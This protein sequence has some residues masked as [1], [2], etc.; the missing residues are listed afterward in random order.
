[1]LFRSGT[2]KTVTATVS[3]TGADAGNYELASTSETDTADI[4]A[5]T[6]TAAL[7][8]DDKVYDGTTTATGACDVSGD[9][10]LIVGDTVTC[11]VT[12]ATFDSAT[13]GTGKTVTATVTLGGADAGGYVLD[14]APITDTAD[15]TPAPLGILFT[16]NG[17][18]PSTSVSLQATVSGACKAGQ[19]VTFILDANTNGNFDDD[20]VLGSPTTNTAGVA[21]FTTS[22]AGG[23]IADVQVSVPDSTNCTGAVGTTVIVVNG[24]GDASNGGGSYNNS[25]RMNFGYGLQVKVDRKTLDRK[26]T[27][28][29][30]SH[31]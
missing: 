24:L 10:D 16:G 27:R 20:P 29:N 21:S 2:G 6:L 30:S 17:Y 11:T 9:P 18:F 19:T 22:I 8:A 14:G 13:A 26:S 5:L 3:L 12:S 1:M 28:L 15:I 31:T 23:T 25:G 4:T 7:T